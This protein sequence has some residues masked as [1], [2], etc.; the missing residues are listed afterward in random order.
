MDTKIIPFKIT[1]NSLSPIR[2]DAPGVSFRSSGLPFSQNS[3][4]G[5]GPI[6][7][8]SDKRNGSHVMMIIR[9]RDIIMPLISELGYNFKMKMRFVLRNNLILNFILVPLPPS[10]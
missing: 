2:N 9:S 4:T 5:T 8:E 10:M 6:S 7:L 3:S 1:S